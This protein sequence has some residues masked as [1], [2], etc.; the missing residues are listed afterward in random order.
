[1]PQKNGEKPKDIFQ[2]LLE[3]LRKREKEKR[4]QLLSSI[5]VKEFFEEGNITINMKICRGID[6]NLC[7]KACPTKA[8]FWRNGEID[9]V[10]ELCVYCGA[11]VLNCIVEDCIQV[12]RKRQNSTIEKYSK[13]SEVVT[14]FNSINGKKRVERVNSIFPTAESYLKRYGKQT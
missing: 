6:C 9:I 11:C 13:P 4:T 7:V 3:T 1:M 14:L 10:K 12:E 5:G 2:I 8:L